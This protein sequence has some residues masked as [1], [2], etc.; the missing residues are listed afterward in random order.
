[1]LK[2]YF[3]AVATLIGTIIG[4]GM[5]SVPYTISKSGIFL[6]FIYLL[7]LGIAQY[8][9]HK[10]FAEIILSTKKKHRLPGYVGKYFGKK[11]KIFTLI[12]VMFGNYGALLAYIIIGGVF[13]NQLLNPFL[14]GNEIIY[15]V[16]LFF[17][18]ALIVLFGLKFIASV[19]LVMTCLLVLSTGMIAWHGFGFININHYSLINWDNIF[20]PYGPV[21]FAIGG[22][23]AI[24]AVCRLLIH[25]K[26]KIKSAIAL[27]TFIPIVIIAIFTV[28]VV[29]VTGDN[30]SVDTLTGLRS[31]FTNGVI[32]FVLIFGLLSIITSFLVIA[33][34]VRE[35]YWWDFGVNKNISWF[36][37]CFIPFIFYVVGLHNLIKVISL[38][39]A[40]IGGLAGIIIIW[41]ALKVKKKREQKSIIVNKL[42]KE[43]AYILSLLFILG[44]FYEIFGILK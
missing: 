43:V 39:G 5:F 13:A 42:S 8:Y 7:V 6:F 12:V 11:W 36:L 20:L 15:S 34:S 14:G 18:E 37:A 17:L 21:F 19:E 30:T 3:Y 41:L 35:T 2:N 26:E 25:K 27:G 22:G 24:P 9:L 38:T 28:I 23:T 16:C 32:I 29:G 31:F 44:F 10:L 4:V 1:M 33:Q 40:V